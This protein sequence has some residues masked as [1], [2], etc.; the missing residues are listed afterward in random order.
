[1]TFKFSKKSLAQLEHVN[2]AL[3]VL[4]HKVLEISHIDFGILQGLRTKE[5]QEENIL[6]G[7]SWTKNSRHLTGHAIDF[8]VYLNGAYINGDTPSEYDLYEQVGEIFKSVAKAEG[9]PIIYGGDWKVKDGGHI[10][11]DR[12]AY[13]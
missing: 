7:V 9:I 4:C 11:L 13:P 5:Q 1:M 10:E 2:P 3:V 12:K 8:G 6:K